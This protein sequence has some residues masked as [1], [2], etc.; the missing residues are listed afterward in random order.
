MKSID[1][2]GISGLNVHL[3]T[4]DEE[5]KMVDSRFAINWFGNIVGQNNYSDFDLVYI[6]ATNNLPYPVYFLQ[7]AIY[8]GFN[9]LKD[10]NL[11][12]KKGKFVDDSIEKIRIGFLAAD[13]Y[14]AAKLIQRNPNPKGHFIIVNNNEEVTLLVQEQFKNIQFLTIDREFE[15]SSE[16]KQKAI[17]L[18][19]KLINYLKELNEGIYKK[20]EIAEKIGTKTHNLSRLWKSKQIQSFIKTGYIKVEHHDIKILKKLI[21]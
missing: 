2:I 1:N 9:K 4:K 7:Y 8:N 5:V 18:D 13:F 16:N 21:F 17:T 20:A 19:I 6:I 14:Q 10:L 15:F 12:V 11:K 3:P